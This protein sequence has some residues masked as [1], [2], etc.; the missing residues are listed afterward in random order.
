[1]SQPIRPNKR[2]RLVC[3][4]VVFILV[5]HAAL[6]P[7]LAASVIQATQGIPTVDGS[8][9]Y[10]LVTSFSYD[11]VGHKIGQ[12]DASGRIT[13][14]GYDIRGRM[15]WRRLPLGQV[16]FM[17]YDAGGQLQ[18]T[19][20][21]R[22]YVTTYSYDQRGRLLAKV[23]DAR[24][25]EATLT[26]SYPDENTRIAYRGASAT[27]QKYDPQ[28]GWLNSVSGPNGVVSYSYNAEGQKVAMT[29]PSGTTSY[30]YDVLG[31]LS[32]VNDQP[33]G[34]AS[35]TPIAS[36]GYDAVGNMASLTRGNGVTTRYA[37]DEQNRLATLV[38]SGAGGTLAS[39]TYTLR[40]D[41]KRT[42]IGEN[43]LN[44]DAGRVS[45]RSLA[46]TYDNA[47]KLTSETGQDGNGLAYQNT[48]GYDA[49]GNRTSATAQKAAT[50]GATAWAHTTSV[51]A[52]F[53][54][55]DQ[56][57]TS[58]SSVDGAA[59]QVQTY[60][61]DL[62]GAERSVASTTGTA[63]NTWDFEG[64]MTGTALADASGNA[65]GG[66]ANSFDAQ[67]D[68]LARVADVGKPSKKT[69]SYLVDT[70]T[71]YSQVIE[72]RA[73]D[74]SDAAGGPVL[75]AR[76]VFGGGL[77]PLA[78]WRR[79]ADGSTK[80]FFHLNDGQE[81]VRQLTDV[82]GAVT[83][84]YFY[85]AW[86]NSLAGGSGNTANPFRYTGQQLDP[87][88]RYYLRARFY[89]PGNGRFLSHDPLMGSDDDPLT[90]HRYLYTGNDGINICDPSGQGWLADT[91]ISLG[92]NATLV[93]AG[94]TAISIAGKIAVAGSAYNI[95]SD[96]QS[97]ADIDKFD[98]AN[99]AIE[100]STS[101]FGGAIWKRAFSPIFSGLENVRNV[102]S[103]GEALSAAN[104]IKRIS[105]AIATSEEISAIREALAA[106]GVELEVGTANAIK[107]LDRAGSVA[108]FRWSSLDEFGPTILVR[109]NPTLYELAHEMMHAIH[110][111]VLG[112][113]SY[114]K[115]SLFESEAFVYRGLSTF[116]KEGLNAE[117]VSAAKGYIKQIHS[118]EFAGEQLRFIPVLRGVKDFLGE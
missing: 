23:P 47:G 88:G 36:Y 49:V 111:K 71:S 1:M 8:G 94:G 42:A 72:E 83:D 66:S 93:E 117:E 59:A 97:G 57:T 89:N 60:A 27:T 68:R 19:T 53:N 70:N 34:D 76:Y 73:P 79:M 35:A 80:L 54:D 107:R 25:R 56:L 112:G 101:S 37:Y 100:I 77:A 106:I 5:W 10:D 84:S 108:G 11:E 46:Y 87:D 40:D 105:G 118:D 85:D 75:Q 116:F 110:W 15:V 52:A 12:R 7:A 14:F 63:A 18:S 39:Y 102:F 22:G 74:T 82:T 31:R 9:Q 50:A 109:E 45:T 44:A 24:L 86:G 33:V 78:M 13:R 61:Y 29:S 2:T 67:G 114:G 48:W 17:A 26:Y 69:T 90:L 95:Y 51:S 91:L 28:R 3:W 32:A 92:V 43:V 113:A 103:A 41:G 30:A 4:L 62:N 16:E 81:S 21:F 96:Y 65:A 104:G 115:I 64:K 58:S 6:F 20:D 55:N 38:H 99:V 98:V